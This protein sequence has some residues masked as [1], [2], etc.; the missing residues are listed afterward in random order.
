LIVTALA[1]VPAAQTTTLK[2]IPPPPDVG[3][4]PAD[5][6]K[7]ASGLATKVIT[8]GSGK[9]HPA[10][11]DLVTVNYTGWK[12][13]GTMFD[14]SV[15]RSK[16]AVFPVARVI[17]EPGEGISAMVARRERRLD[18]K[19]WRRGLARAERMLVLTS[20]DRR[21]RPAVQSDQAPPPDTKRTA[22]GLS[23]M[24][25]KPGINARRPTIPATP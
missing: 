12:T 8:P 21:C 5:A 4:P 14:S 22:S 7:T 1:V 20:A 11:D 23:Y 2:T 16:P 10:K 13:D 17:Q 18:R 15:S 19:R 9:E 24:S 25:L 3:A 6:T